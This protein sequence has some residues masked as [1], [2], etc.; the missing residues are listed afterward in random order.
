[1]VQLRESWK[2]SRVFVFFVSFTVT[3][4]VC[5]RVIL[6]ARHNN[7]IKQGQFNFP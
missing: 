6:K 4:A 7:V 5:F 2:Y 3:L 1:M